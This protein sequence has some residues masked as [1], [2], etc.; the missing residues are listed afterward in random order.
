MQASKMHTGK[1]RPDTIFIIAKQNS[2]NEIFDMFPKKAQTTRQFYFE[3]DINIDDKY[4]ANA[5]KKQ[6][7]VTR[8]DYLPEYKK[9]KRPHKKQTDE[10]KR[11]KHNE[12]V[13]RYKQQHKSVHICSICGKE[14]KGCQYC[15][16]C[17]AKK[18]HERQKQKAIEEGRTIKICPICGKEH[19]RLDRETCGDKR[20]FKKF[21]K[22]S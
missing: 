5:Y 7:K 8:I 3:D 21:E 17:K 13:K 22:K 2:N 10:Q 19:W 4:I 6:G 15:A 20:C 12:K 16:D 1:L 11:Q 18:E 9:P 14:I